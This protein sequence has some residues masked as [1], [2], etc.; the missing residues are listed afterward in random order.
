MQEI[1]DRLFRFA[2]VACVLNDKIRCHFLHHGHRREVDVGQASQL[3]AGLHAHQTAADAV[4]DGGDVFLK[5]SEVRRRTDVVSVNASEVSHLHL[6]RSI[7]D[8][9]LARFRGDVVHL[10]DVDRPVDEMLLVPV[11]LHLSLE[12]RIAPVT[13]AGFTGQL[14]ALQHQQKH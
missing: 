14:F 11:P 8:L 5:H 6:R 12:L 7:H 9:S 4:L 2:V 1:L 13:D 3:H 10:D